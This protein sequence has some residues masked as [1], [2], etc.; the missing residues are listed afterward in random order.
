M[1]SGSL[2]DLDPVP[3]P[4]Q[5]WPFYV[6]WTMGA[7]VVGLV[8]VSRLP[9]PLAPEGAPAAAPAATMAPIRSVA[10]APLRLV[11]P[12][13]QPVPVRGSPV[14]PVPARR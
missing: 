2:T 3:A 13:P 7:C 10:P 6:A 12:L 5:R 11:H 14:P 9:V 8:L 4:E 1:T